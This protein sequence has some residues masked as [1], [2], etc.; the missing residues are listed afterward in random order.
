M[1]LFAYCRVNST[2]RHFFN[3]CGFALDRTRW[4]RPEVPRNLDT[5]GKSKKE[6]NKE[7]R[8]ILKDCASNLVSRSSSIRII[9]REREARPDEEVVYFRLDVP[10]DDFHFLV[11]GQKKL[12]GKNGGSEELSFI[13]PSE[14]HKPWIAYGGELVYSGPI[15]KLAVKRTNKIMPFHRL[16]KKSE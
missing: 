6:I 8:T 14:L 12:F 1:N 4:L 2:F 5:A 11:K 7:I 15:I 13:K 16:Y 10:N 9:K 3:C